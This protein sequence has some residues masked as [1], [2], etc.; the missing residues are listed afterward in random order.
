MTNFQVTDAWSESGWHMQGVSDRDRR[1]RKKNPPR[2]CKPRDPT[3]AMAMM[4]SQLRA[5][6]RAAMSRRDAAALQEIRQS[7]ARELA[8]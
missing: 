5:E 3:T 4:L 7:I 6:E 8:E 1:W 2:R